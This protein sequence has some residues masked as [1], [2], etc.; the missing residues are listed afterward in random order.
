M[1]VVFS[2]Q[3]VPSSLRS[4]GRQHA[5]LLC[6][7]LSPG[8]CANSFPLSQWCYLTILSSVTPFS[9]CLQPFPAAG[10]FPVG[11]LFAWGGQSS[12]ASASASVLPMTIQDWFSLGLN[13]LISLLFKELS[14]VFSNT[15]IWN[16]VRWRIH[17]SWRLG[18]GHPWGTVILSS[19]STLLF[20]SI[21]QGS[22]IWPISE[23]GTKNKSDSSCKMLSSEP[24]H[25]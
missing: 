4:H 23:L 24:P 10:Y 3:A 16:H 17:K 13:G 7:L 20:P 1:V 5:S 6:P 8:V 19:S 11:Q 18:L 15:T 14:R 25:N 22:I 2:R 9:F 21:K 12:G